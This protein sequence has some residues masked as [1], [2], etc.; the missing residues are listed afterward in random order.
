MQACG[1]A[2]IS[3][4]APVLNF[5]EKGCRAAAPVICTVGPVHAMLA[6]CTPPAGVPVMLTLQVEVCADAR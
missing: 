1:L 4:G 5:A 2:S 3:T 6:A